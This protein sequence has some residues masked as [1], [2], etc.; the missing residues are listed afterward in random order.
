MLALTYHIVP[1][2]VYRCL[3]DAPVRRCPMSGDFF[4]VFRFVFLCAVRESAACH[5]WNK[6]TTTEWFSVCLLCLRIFCYFPER[7]TSC[8]WHGR[9]AA[10][11]DGADEECATVGG[12]FTR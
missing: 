3:G 9:G 4:A 7:G 5:L 8:K 12:A 10:V 11:R 2:L 6:G 1:I